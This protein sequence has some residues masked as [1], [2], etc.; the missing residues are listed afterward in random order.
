VSID[1]VSALPH[2]FGGPSGQGVIRTEPAD[3]RVEEI[4]VVEPDG[5]GEHCLLEI[6]KTNTNTDWVARLLGRHAGVKPVDVSYAGLKDR[7][8]VTRQWFSVR[9]A[10]KP[11]PDWSVLESPELK[12]LQVARHSRKLRTGALKGNRFILRVR[13][14]DGDAGRLAEQMSAMAEQGIPN[15]F[16]AQRFGRGGGN[17]E[18]ARALLAGKLGRVSRSKRGIYL[19]AAR[20]YLFN[21]VL[22]YRVEKGNW[23]SLLEGERFLLDGSRSHFLAEQIDAEIIRRFREGDI[24][25]TGPMWGRGAS[26]VEAE[27]DALEQQAL[28]GQSEWQAGLEG[29]GLKMER[30]ALRALVGDLEWSLEGSDLRLSFSLPKGSFATSLLRECVDIREAALPGQQG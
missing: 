16:G 4:T 12:I 30:R 25:S 18:R 28:E 7:H 21:K 13:G 1:A 24:H 8:A 26:G 27:V 29:V 2:A 10:G 23:N 19:S 17:L 22:A 6:E 14:F 20:S 3:F 9:L 5:E 11:E 15:Y